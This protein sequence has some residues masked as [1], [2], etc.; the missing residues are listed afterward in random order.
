MKYLSE[1]NVQIRDN[2]LEASRMLLNKTLD[3]NLPGQYYL[4]VKVYPHHVQRENKMAAGAG[5]DRLSTGMSQS[6]GV[7]MGRA[8]IVHPGKEIFLIGVLNEKSILEARK[9]L[10]MIKTKIPCKGRIVFEK[11]TN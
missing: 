5:A 3:K 1:E 8:A 9:A 2:A 4:E 10:Q 7:T 11:I 6:Y